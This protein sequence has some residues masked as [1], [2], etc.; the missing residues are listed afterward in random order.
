MMK[1]L[2]RLTEQALAAIVC[3]AALWL[4]RNPL[5]AGDYVRRIASWFGA[6]DRAWSVGTVG[7]GIV[8]AAIGVT[9]GLFRASSDEPGSYWEYDFG[10]P[11]IV[12]I[13]IGAAAVCWLVASALTMCSAGNTWGLLPLLLSGWIS[14]RFAHRIRA[15]W[16]RFAY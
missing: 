10:L 9:V 11:S 5:G 12:T 4:V 16:A 7:A 3:A 14:V 2:T 15:A 6:V 1:L 13:L 8:L